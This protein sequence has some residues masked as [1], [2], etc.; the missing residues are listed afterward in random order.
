M[1][2]HKIT[3]L[4]LAGLLC[5]S[6]CGTPSHHTDSTTAT[7]TTGGTAIT[8]TT[9]TSSAAED[10]TSATEP[11]TT[12][13]LTT[14]QTPQPIPMKEEKVLPEPYIDIEFYADGTARDIKEH[15]DCTMPE[16][17]LGRVENAPVSF[18]G[19]TYTVPHLYTDRGGA[20]MLTYKHLVLE[21]DVYELMAGGFTIETFLVNGNTLSASSSEQCMTNA[22]QSGGFGLSIKNGKLGFGVYTDT[23]YKTASFTG[24]YD[25]ENLTHLLGVYDPDSKTV[26]LYINGKQVK[27]EDAAGTFRPAQSGC[28][29]YIVLGGDIGIGVKTE[30]HATNTRIADFKLYPTALKPAEVTTAYESAVAALTGN[31]PAFDLIYKTVDGLPEGIANA[32]YTNVIESFADVYEPLTSITVAPTVWQWAKDGLSALAAREERPAT[33]LFDL[34]M[35]GNVLHA[36]D[37]AGQDLGTAEDAVKAL[38]GK[39]IPAFRVI[40]PAVADSLVTLLNRH[41]IGDC[42]VVCADGT[43]MKEICDATACARPVLDCSAN[44]AVDPAALFSEA[45]YYGTKRILLPAAILTQENM[46]ALHTRSLTVFA[47]LE[48]SD[49]AAIHNAIFAAADGILTADSGAVLDYYRTFTETTISESTLIV[50]HRGDHA[51]YPD[52]TM[53]SFV[54]GAESGANIIELDIWMTADG[55]L[56]L[57]HDSATNGWSEILECTKSTRAQLEALTCTSKYAAE[58]DRLAFFEEVLDYF[59]KNHTDIILF[60]EIKDSRT[61][62]GDK[63]VEMTKAYGML[64]RVIFLRSSL[65]FDQYLFNTHR[66]AVI[67]NSAPIY[68]RTDLK[69][70]LALSCLDL[71]EVPTDYFTQWKD[72]NEDLMRMLRHRGVS[73]GPWTSNSAADTDAHFYLG[74]ANM[75]SNFPHQCDK[76]V[77]FLKAEEA[78][79]GQVTVIAEYYDGTTEDVSA[80]AEFI[81]LSGLLTW[82]NGKVSGSGAY[83]F[84][85]STSLP[86]R[87]DLT[88]FVYSLSLCR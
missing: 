35:K 43:L 76:Y 21:S 4:L 3:A 55:H 14:T 68:P 85:L 36:C 59:S 28:H 26:F 48:T 58:S 56:V 37:S 12:T 70:A 22:G 65:S 44:T 66:V 78:A 19:K 80:R 6:A 10:T 52:N 79:D 64:D 8:E 51:A 77:R 63:A 15:V 81:P 74:Y 5:L 75:T 54:S 34:Y 82:Q 25:T 71:A 20:I 38:N 29:P 47:L 45:T 62:A 49:T 88:Y 53:R 1:R 33:V 83:A 24:K 60:A 69:R 7:E 9:A 11:Q 67:R 46:L 61:A 31:E 73:Y 18:G 41:N 50:A 42:F 13:A 84:R 30:L 87:T 17:A 86:T 32:A 16:T 40:D 57:N 72:A 39:I 23:S 2:K 27:A